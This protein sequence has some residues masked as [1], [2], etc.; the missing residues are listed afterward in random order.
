[1]PNKPHSHSQTS[2]IPLYESHS[3]TDSDS[4]SPDDMAQIERFSQGLQ[5]KQT[6]TPPPPQPP[7]R[8]KQQQIPSRGLQKKKSILPQDVD[9]QSKRHLGRGTFCEV[10]EVSMNRQTFAMKRV[11]SRAVAHST[12]RAIAAATT[13]LAR[14]AALL[15]TTKHENIVQMHGI[16]TGSLMSRGGSIVSNDDEDG[17][18]ILVDRLETTLDRKI[19]QWQTEQKRSSSWNIRKNQQQRLDRLMDRLEVALGIAKGLKYLHEKKIVHCDIRPENIGFDQDGVVKL[20]DF[21]LAMKLKH[22]KDKTIQGTA[23]SR[24]YMAPEIHM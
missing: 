2:P 14:E 22:G 10:H 15:A 8:P 7:Q 6:Y 19:I 18:F 20:F 23:G 3:Q 16:S 13:D 12:P 24:A 11:S 21:G 17:F 9:F 1:M 4:L 5:K